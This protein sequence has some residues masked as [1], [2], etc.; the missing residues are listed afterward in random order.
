MC[1]GCGRVAAGLRLARGLQDVSGAAFA[2]AVPV[3]AGRAVEEGSGDESPLQ[4]A[5]PRRVAP[6]ATTASPI[7]VR[8]M[9]L[10]RS[11]LRVMV[12]PRSA[13]PVIGTP[14]AGRGS[15]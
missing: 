3:A 1:P 5:R 9:A 4:P 8:L 13:R 6:V 12:V 14:R 2:G 7:R 11:P 10:L 15:P